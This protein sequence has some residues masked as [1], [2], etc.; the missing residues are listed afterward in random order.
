MPEPMKKLDLPTPDQP[1]CRKCGV[2]LVVGDNQTPGRAK[3]G[4]KICSE[5][6]AKRAA[7]YRATNKAKIKASSAAH[8]AANREK[9]KARV[10][11][12]QID[13]KETVAAYRA[14][15]QIDNAEAI[16]VTKAQY[17][18]ENREAIR[19]LQAQ[20][21]AE[22]PEALRE[23]R[24]DNAEAT[25]E[26]AAQYRTDNADYRA[27][28]D[29]TQSAVDRGATLPPGQ[30]KADAARATMS[31]Y[32][33]A[34]ALTE[35]T[36]VKH[37]VDHK[38]PCARGGLHAPSNLQVITATE[39]NRKGSREVDA[40]LSDWLAG[41]IK[42]FMAD[43]SPDTWEVIMSAMEAWLIEMGDP[44]WCNHV[45]VTKAPCAPKVAA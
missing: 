26:W 15:Y 13:N 29:G 30:T 14:Q 11:Q 18:A 42:C 5:C 12:Y 22:N 20:Y 28:Y 40:F 27:A 34:R 19:A 7:T 4:D 41:R 44:D 1:C 3:W 36:G 9:I 6:Q 2:V 31:F 38:T 23:Y 17:Y 8:Y 39:N 43:L 32:V 33:K 45:P 16:R 25:R 24:I 37:H 10:A 35:D 21:R